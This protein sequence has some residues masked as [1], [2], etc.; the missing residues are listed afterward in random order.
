MKHLINWILGNLFNCNIT[1]NFNSGIE[2]GF[3]NNPWIVDAY[4][5]DLVVDVGANEGQFCQIA[6]RYFNKVDIYTFEPIPDVYDILVHRFKDEERVFPFN[7]GIGSTSTKK[8][9]NIFNQSATSSFLEASK[10]QGEY[11]PGSIDRTKKI[12]V[13]L[14]SLSDILSDT[15][16]K[17]IFLKIDVQ[18]YELEVLKGAENIF[19]KVNMILVECSFVEFYIGQPLFDDIYSFLKSKGYE[20][21]GQI[22]SLIGS[23]GRPA[24]IDA[25]FEKKRDC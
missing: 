20:Y 23:Q 25:V 21:R 15:D 7:V 11:Y 17:N 12:E 6:L 9:F 2:R 14:V 3:A 22:D 10:H 1:R 4:D 19:D 8:V 13:S 24:Q 18:G 5:Y 16:H